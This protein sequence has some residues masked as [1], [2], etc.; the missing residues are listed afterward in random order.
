MSHLQVDYFFLVIINWVVFDYILLNHCTR[1]PS[2]CKPVRNDAS[3]LCLESIG[4][5]YVP[6]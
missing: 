2:A 5:E 3:V 1:L 4:C 6:Y